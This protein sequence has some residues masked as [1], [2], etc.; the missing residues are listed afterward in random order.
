M[1][2]AFTIRL[3]EEA[4]DDASFRQ[5]N[6]RTFRDSIPPGT[7]VDEEAFARHHAWILQA[8]GYADG[9]RSTVLVAEV[10]GRYAGHCWIGTQVDFFT[11][12]PEAWIYDLTVGPA[13]RRRGLGH[14]LLDAA[15]N[16]VRSR[17]FGYLGL[18]VMAHN[19]AAQELYR[20][21][22]YGVPAMTL[23]KPLAGR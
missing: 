3:F 22:G 2:L 13:W 23:R 10:G 12:R 21:R 4:R 11:N 19:A 8:Y 18:Q 1:S 5:L 20:A 14:A 17:G 15:E 9:R 7:P 16:F 6:L